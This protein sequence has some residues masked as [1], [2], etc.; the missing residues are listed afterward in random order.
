MQEKKITGKT[1]FEY[2]VIA[3]IAV[4]FAF[5]YLIFIIPNKFAPAGLNGI[6]TMI[7]YKLGFSIGYFSLIINVPLCIFAYFCVNK[8]FALKS[9]TFCLAY[10]GAYL[11]LQRLDLSAIAY[12]AGG[13]DTIFPCLIAGLLSGCVYGFCGRMNA[14]TGGTDIVS[15]AISQKNPMLNFFW[16]TFTLNAIVAFISLFVYGTNGGEFVL[17]YKPVCLCMLYCFLSSFVGNRML[18]G[19]KVA[20]K[21]LIITP[22]VDELEREILTV[23][24]HSATRINGKGVYT[25]TDKDILICVVNKHQIVD[26]KNILK[27]YPNTFTC[28]EMVNETVGNF[29]KIK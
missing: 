21:F 13:V 17:D 18:Q 16:V 1:I 14:S 24:H 29:K 22:H 2:V 23:L 20:Y 19:G 4:L 3:V 11:L 12:N 26:F 28:I 27:K 6:A 25:E 7:Q 15:K 10:S 5:M 8:E 9:L